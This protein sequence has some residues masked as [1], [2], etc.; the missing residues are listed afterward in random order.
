MEIKEGDRCN[1]RHLSNSDGFEM[2]RDGLK[3]YLQR[4]DAASVL[5][6]LPAQKDLKRR[7]VFYLYL[8]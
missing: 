5:S 2:L 1:K 6:A 4:G 8:Y 7:G 3:I